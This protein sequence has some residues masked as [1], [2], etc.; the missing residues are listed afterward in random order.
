MKL[1]VSLI[2]L[3]STVLAGAGIVSSMPVQFA[4][5]APATTQTRTF[6]DTI[7]NPGTVGGNG[8]DRPSQNLSPNSAAK[9]D[10]ILSG[11]WN[12]FTKI[13]YGLIA[14]YA[15]L[16]LSLAALKY[17]GARGDAKKVAEARSAIVQTVL[18]IA[19]LTASVTAV[20]LIWSFVR[21][22]V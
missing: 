22:F 1:I 7:P 6:S 14:A 12:R 21:I 18:G 5:A 3:G 4:A 19:L 8:T 13:F 17:G 11:L 9:L 10:Q 16:A 15:V 20:S 2:L